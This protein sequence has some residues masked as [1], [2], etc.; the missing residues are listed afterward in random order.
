LPDRLR[1]ELRLPTPDADGHY[2]G[3]YGHD[4]AEEVDWLDERDANGKPV[5]V[6]V[7]I[8]DMGSHMWEKTQKERWAS[9]STPIDGDPI[10]I[11]PHMLFAQ[12]DEAFRLLM[13]GPGTKDDDTLPQSILAT[14]EEVGFQVA[15]A[16]FELFGAPT[17]TQAIHRY[18]FRE[19]PRLEADRPKAEEA[20]VSPGGTF[21]EAVQ[22]ALRNAGAARFFP[23]G[24]T[25]RWLMPRERR[26]LLSQTHALI[27]LQNPTPLN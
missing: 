16:I 8:L 18:Y 1:L 9:P 7:I 6:G 3:R 25:R 20:L 21:Y 19:R 12:L 26:E 22:E 23:D 27:L 24:V 2:Q 14:A 13:G 17:L 4:H 5:S 15:S 11:E 10:R